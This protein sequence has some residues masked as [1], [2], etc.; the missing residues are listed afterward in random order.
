MMEVGQEINVGD[1]RMEIDFEEIKKGASQEF[2]ESIRKLSREGKSGRRGITFLKTVD[3]ED[4]FC[5]YLATGFYSEKHNKTFHDTI[6]YYQFNKD[7]QSFLLDKMPVSFL[8]N[9]A[10]I[11]ITVT[12]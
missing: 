3:S 9:F 12:G 1:L 10:S 7:D 4:F 5:V 2:A 8:R 6:Y 11:G